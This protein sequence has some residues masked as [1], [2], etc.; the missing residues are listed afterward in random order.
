[1]FPDKVRA[2]LKFNVPLAH[3]IMAGADILAVT[4]RFEP[5]G[6]IQ[7]QAMQYGIVC[8]LFFISIIAFIDFIVMPAVNVYIF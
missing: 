7:L 4:S 5:C 1:M 3:G 2:H 6:L 8:Y